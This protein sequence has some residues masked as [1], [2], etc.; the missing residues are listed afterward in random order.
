MARS[1][2]SAKFAWLVD[3][4]CQMGLES[5]VN[6][7][8]VTL[9]SLVCVAP[10]G[11]ASPLTSPTP[12]GVDSVISRL[13]ALVS[14]DT[15][16]LVLH[17]AAECQLLNYCK[18]SHKCLLAPNLQPLRRCAPTPGPPPHHAQKQ[19]SRAL[20]TPG[21]ARFSLRSRLP[22][23]PRL[24][25]ESPDADTRPDCDQHNRGTAER[26]VVVFGAFYAA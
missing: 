15:G 23:G 10:P 13:T 25:S 5:K 19:K 2:P 6:G 11:L 17:S 1:S 9:V 20:G 14:C 16:I 22:E 18:P 12:D 26:K 7:V 3:K 8:V 4:A 24:A 21:A